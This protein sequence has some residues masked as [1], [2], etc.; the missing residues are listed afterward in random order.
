M[1]MHCCLLPREP[2]LPRTIR[3]TVRA[4]VPRQRPV[5]ETHV[6]RVRELHGHRQLA[7]V[8]YRR[9]AAVS[10]RRGR[11]SVWDWRQQSGHRR[12]GSAWRRS[13]E[14]RGRRAHTHTHLTWSHGSFRPA[15]L[16]WC[17]CSALV[18]C[19]IFLYVRPP[20]VANFRYSALVPHRFSVPLSTINRVTVISFVRAVYT[21][22]CILHFYM[23][24]VRISRLVNYFATHIAR[25]ILNPR[26]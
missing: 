15:S 5:Y 1:R 2:R 7:A 10:D 24:F 16:R 17:C 19:F 8:R 4:A 25:L 3:L 12:D 26:D 23:C 11:V 9:T 14:Q 18:D 21:I 22:D 20:S 13:S 6:K